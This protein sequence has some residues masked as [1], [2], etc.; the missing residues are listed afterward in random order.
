MK[1]S[2]FIVILVSVILSACATA[3][4]TADPVEQVQAS[5]VAAANT[6]VALTQAAIPTATPIP[7]T[8]L[9]SATPLPSPTLLALPT[10]SIEGS[11]TIEPP[12][13]SAGSDPCNAPMSANPAGPLTTLKINNGTKAPVTVSVYLY[14]TKFGECGYRGYNLGPLDSVYL[15][16]LPQGCY[17]AFAL[18]NDPKKPSKAFSSQLMCPNNDDKWTMVVQTDVIKFYSP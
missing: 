1:G 13:G 3:A 16:D 10:L 12:S 18:I 7:P 9:P 17:S 14:K 8:P 4:P 5:A 11:P 2:T 6:M 15:T